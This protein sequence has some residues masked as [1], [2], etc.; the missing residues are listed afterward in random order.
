[1][2]GLYVCKFPPGSTD[3]TIQ[4]EVDI[5]QDITPVLWTIETNADNP[6]YPG[7]HTGKLEFP[8]GYPMQQIFIIWVTPVFSPYVRFTSGQGDVSSPF[9]LG[10]WSPFYTVQHVLQTMA[11]FLALQ[12]LCRHPP[13]PF[14]QATVDIPWRFSDLSKVAGLA[15]TDE[16]A[17]YHAAQFFARAYNRVGRAAY[18]PSVDEFQRQASITAIRELVAFYLDGQP[19]VPRG[20]FEADYTAAFNGVGTNSEWIAEERLW[21]DALSQ[22]CG[23]GFRAFEM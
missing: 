11:N 9:D 21:A 1:M 5:T 19:P 17:F 23:F 18:D 15:S 16:D 12:P 8:E 4:I 14:A 20:R 13:P 6:F 10:K 22:A 7:R 2:G 3:T